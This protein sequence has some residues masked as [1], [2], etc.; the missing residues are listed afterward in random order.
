M[1]DVSEEDKRASRRGR[2]L[3]FQ[4]SNTVMQKAG[5][6]LQRN[7]HNHHNH[8]TGWVERSPGWLS[9]IGWKPEEC[10]MLLTGW[11]SW[12]ENAF[13]TAQLES[14]GGLAFKM[15]GNILKRQLGGS[16]YQM[17]GWVVKIL[18]CG[19]TGFW[20][21]SRRW[22]S[23]PNVKWVTPKKEKALALSANGL[24]WL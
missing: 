18:L 12:G 9:K 16:E 2:A 8:L 4:A 6:H 23:P 1:E 20:D 21:L 5:R 19:W 11:G 15:K 13:W 17:I 3:V 14:G 24:P 10:W 22:D 7:P